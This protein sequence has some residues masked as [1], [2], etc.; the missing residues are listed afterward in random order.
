MKTSLIYGLYLAL[1]GLLL[2]LCLYFAGFH[3]EAEKMISVQWPSV[4]IFILLAIV[5]IVLG[6]KARRGET[7]VTEDFGY[8]RALLT[9]VL[10]GAF[11]CIF[12][13]VTNLLYTK[14]INRGFDVV[15]AQVRAT[16]WEAQ[17]W[18]SDRIEKTEAWVH[19]PMGI[20]IFGG[21]FVLFLMFIYTVIS[22]IAAA[23]LK[24]PAQD[25]LTPPVAA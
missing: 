20:I 23:F 16:Q 7:P 24:R 2:N 14:V 5:L 10:V 13:I 12:G 18:S 21:I 4:G 9:G 19:S 1:A 25:S 11:S 22:L 8:G 6:I 17:G 15:M 3:S